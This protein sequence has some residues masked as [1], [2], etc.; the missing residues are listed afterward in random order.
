MREV[1]FFEVAFVGSGMSPEQ[2]DC[3][4]GGELK[5]GRA[6]QCDA[7]GDAMGWEAAKVIQAELMKT[8]TLNAPRR[9]RLLHEHNHDPYKTKS[10]LSEPAFCPVCK[11]VFRKGRWEWADSWPADANEITC[12]ACNRSRDNFPAGIITLR[13]AFVKQHNDEILNLIRNEEMNEKAEHPLHRIMKIEEH[14]NSIIVSA[15]DIHL[16]RRIAESLHRAHKGKLDI[17]YDREGYFIRVNW[18]RD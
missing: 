1:I 13:G 14:P 6:E 11:A 7:G 16:P 8:Q 15:T 9:D 5:A 18:L 10:K 2:V 12:Q 4:P 3:P 17:H